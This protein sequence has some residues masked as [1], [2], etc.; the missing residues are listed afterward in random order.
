MT[1]R[2]LVLL[3]LAACFKVRGYQDGELRCD[4][5]RCPPEM[6]CR[7]DGLCYA[8]GAATADAPLALPADAALD[9]RPPV[10]APLDVPQPIDAALDVPLIDARECV[11]GAAR[12]G[13]GAPSVLQRCSDATGLWMDVETCDVNLGCYDGDGQDGPQGY[14]GVCSNGKSRCNTGLQT[15][16]DGLW[17]MPFDCSFIGQSCFEPTPGGAY[18]GVCLAGVIVCHGDNR[19]QCDLGGQA[20]T[21]LTACTWGCDP[22]AG[23]TCCA[24]PDCGSMVC[25]SSP[26]N[27]C[28]KTASCGTCNGDCCPDG[29]TCCSFTTFCCG[30]TCCGPGEQCCEPNICSSGS[31]P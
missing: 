25:G 17:G 20:Y 11:A 18:C 28:G 9:V 3:A 27:A 1:R 5:G 26:V 15:C 23:V 24:A 12:C 2:W 31:C 4:E 22:A 21:T 7:T 8:I 10:D 6:E 19:D 13:S 14:C 30:Q 16:T 29:L